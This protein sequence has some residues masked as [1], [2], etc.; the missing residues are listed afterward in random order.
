M[1]K[2]KTILLTGASGFIGSH[3]AERLVARG[4]KVH[5]LYRRENPPQALVS[6]GERYG[7]MI[8]LYRAD[9][10]DRERIAKALEDVEAVI[11][12]A[13]LALDWGSM[14]SF[15]RTN[16]LATAELLAAS[17]QA[18]AK[19]F[20]YM[21]S[22]VVQGFGPHVN[23]TEEG[24]YYPL[25]YPYPITKKMAEDYALSRNEADFRVT[26]IRPCNVYGPGDRTST[27]AMYKAILEGVF[28]YIG[29]GE[30]LTCPIYIDDLC[31][32]TLAALDSPRT[33]GQALLLT[34]G[35][36]VSWKEYCRVMYEAVGSKK[37]P[38]GFPTPLAALSAR[39]MCFGAKLLGVG[40]PPP[41]TSY[42]V[43]QA[44]QD[45]H[46]SNS[47]AR[48]LIGFS[49]EVFYEEGLRRTAEAFLKERAA[50]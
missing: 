45:Y 35:S 31:A 28:G 12:A 46:F 7:D 4:D 39:I 19:V 3:L 40:K 6:L 15:V 13:A 33:A 9:L 21:S 26:A 10:G 48:S 5:A 44:S 22:A 18:G 1:S 34:D 17:R 8:R 43:D 49:P 42:R 50:K 2:G 14:E 20:L 47:K 37:K 25:K 41:L 36:K 27:Y 29:D 30:A 16:Y 38:V 32:G 23:S 11:H 24:P